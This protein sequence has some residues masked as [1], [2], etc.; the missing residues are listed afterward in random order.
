MQFEFVRL[1]EYTNIDENIAHHKCVMDAI[2]ISPEVV[3][4]VTGG[5]IP[6]I[7]GTVILGISWP[8]YQENPIAATQNDYNEYGECTA[9]YI[10]QRIS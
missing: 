7:S 3:S 9:M 4:A 5:N 2:C 6:E 1:L 8:K 10:A